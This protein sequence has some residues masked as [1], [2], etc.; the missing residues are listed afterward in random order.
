MTQKP[1]EWVRIPE[2]DEVVRY[3]ARYGGMCRDCADED[4]IC[5]HSGLPCGDECEKAILHVIKALNYGFG[6]GYL[7]ASPSPEG[8]RRLDVIWG[9]QRADTLTLPPVPGVDREVVARLSAF[10]ERTEA[11]GEPW[12]AHT[13]DLRAL[14]ALVSPL[15]GKGEGSSS[16]SLPAHGAPQSS[17]PETE[18]TC[19]LD[20]AS[21]WRCHSC[22]ALFKSAGGKIVGGTC[23]QGRPTCPLVPA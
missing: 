3:V 1:E 2:T 12:T 10:V 9:G 14:L 6:R 20:G 15:E 21:D 13:A 4:G 23:P 16:A 11:W 19:D 5:P 18:A 22:G 17:A 8:T 7:A